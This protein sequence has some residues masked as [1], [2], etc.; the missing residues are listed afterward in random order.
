MNYYVDEHIKNTKRV[1]PGQGR[2]DYLRYDMNE[3]PE[4]LPK[5]FVDSVLQEITPEFLSVYPEPDKF[6]N[7]Y[8]S[9]IHAQYENV[10]ATNGSDMAIRYLLETF[11]EEGKEVVTVAP[12]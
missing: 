6:L 2:Y 10:L 7:K 9:F 5:E 12:F 1:F 8:A 3:N 4:G 11:G